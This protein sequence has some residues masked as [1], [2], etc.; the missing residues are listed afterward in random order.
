[1]GIIGALQKLMFSS[2]THAGEKPDLAEVFVKHLF[3]GRVGGVQHFMIAGDKH[4]RVVSKRGA[5]RAVSD[6][7]G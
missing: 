6:G 4:P 2:M 7:Q 5:P 1:M 3:R